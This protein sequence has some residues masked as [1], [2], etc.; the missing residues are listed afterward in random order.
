[1]LV[2]GD[3]G[4]V[5]VENYNNPDV[6]GAL[7]NNGALSNSQRTSDLSGTK[8]TGTETND[9][10]GNNAEISELSPREKQEIANAEIEVKNIYSAL[11]DE[12]ETLFMQV[13]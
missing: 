7:P 12:F 13:F 5:S 8:T 6:G 1:M 9:R 4:A 2:K 10:S 3:G 11:L